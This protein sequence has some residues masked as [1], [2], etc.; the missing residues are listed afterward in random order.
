MQI[1]KT[2][3]LAPTT[4]LGARMH[5]RTSAGFKHRVLLYDHA[6]STMENHQQLAQWIKELMKWDGEM[7]GGQTKEGDWVWVFVEGSPKI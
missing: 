7:V 6:L 1:I 5:G 4:N 2:R 3:Y